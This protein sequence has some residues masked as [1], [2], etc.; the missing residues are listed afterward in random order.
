[1]GM[2]EVD[3]SRML[4]LVIQKLQGVLDAPLQID[5]SNVKAIEQAL[6]LY[7]GKP[8]VNSVNGEPASL[9]AVLP[10]VKRYGAVV[11]GL[12]LDENGL[13]SGVSE[14]EAVYY[15]S[16]DLARFFAMQQLVDQYGAGHI[17]TEE[18]EAL[19]AWNSES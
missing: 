5:S 18:W 11:I 1:M 10:L 6:R 4:P 7:N 9:E 2:P 16:N 19:N 12:T 14:G 8:I 15:Q 13:V 3:E 17:P